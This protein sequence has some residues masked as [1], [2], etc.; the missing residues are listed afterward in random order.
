MFALAPILTWLGNL[1]GGP[2][3]Q[4]ALQAFQAKLNSE[5]SVVVEK[6][7]LAAQALSLATREAELQTQYRIAVIGKW[8]TPDNLMGYAAAIYYGKL[9]IWDK[10]LG[11]G[12][13]DP[14]AGWAATTSAMIVSYYFA[15]MGVVAALRIW[16]GR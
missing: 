8:Y 3:I 13:T 5:N 7:L 15:K 4:A 6:E 10:V 14:L 1:L 11:W 16:T 9:L 12:T 2:F